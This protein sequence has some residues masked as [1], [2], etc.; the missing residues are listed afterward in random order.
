MLTLL[1]SFCVYNGS[2]KMIIKLFFRNHI[3]LTI[4]SLLFKR[5]F[6]L[7]LLY[8]IRIYNYFL[9][10][11]KSLS[12]M[13]LPQESFWSRHSDVVISISTHTIATRLR[14]DYLKIKQTYLYIFLPG[15]SLVDIT[16]IDYSLTIT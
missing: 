7:G 9:Y 16:R 11:L 1:V 3:S 2:N 4:L 12:R 13:L 10:L 15:F 6:N 14:V 8:T 5:M